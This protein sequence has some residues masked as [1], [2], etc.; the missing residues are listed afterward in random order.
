MHFF[1][2][3]V[4]MKF[5]YFLLI[6][7]FIVFVISVSAQSKMG[8]NP[9]FIQPSSLLELESLS[10][11]LRLPRIQLDNIQ[12]WTLDGT[13]V[14]GM[15]IFNETGSAPKGMYYWSMSLSQ[16]VNVVNSTE[17]VAL[18]AAGTSVSNIFANNKLS[19]TVN[20]V[21]GLGI[22][23]INSN[24][25]S[26]INGV[27]TSTVNGVVSSPG[28]NLISSVENGLSN[29]N[30]NAQLGG[31]LIM[32]T[33][34]STTSANTLAIKGLLEGDANADSLLVIA[35][36]TGVIRKVNSSMV[37]AKTKVYKL[38]AFASS[39]G[40]KRFATPLAMTDVEKVKVYRNGI[41][42]EFI[43]VDDT[44]IDLEPSAVCYKDDEVK[45]TQL[46]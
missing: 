29:G 45:I 20:G 7:L 3:V 4:L 43:R 19:T 17:L 14:S 40:Q 5:K 12:A 8:D 15:L 10:K 9:A 1:N 36:N 30:G 26:I 23:I 42:V 2:S 25:L 34:I 39:D 27:L 32:P 46:F 35:S 31:P 11:G 24:S 18:I 6:V 33:T 13:A 44:H 37:G 28:L 22:D 16:W 38:V 41:N 21:T